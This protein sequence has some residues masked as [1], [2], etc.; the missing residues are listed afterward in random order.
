MKKFSFIFTTILLFSITTSA[1]IWRVNNM[2]GV[3]ADFTTAQAAHNAASAG[4][5]I[6]LE[7]SIYNYGSI[8]TTKQLV[9]ISIGSFLTQNP[10]NQFSTTP[11]TLSTINVNTGSNGSVFSVVTNSGININVPSITIL[12]THLT[13]G[14]GYVISINST[15]AVIMQCYLNSPDYVYI[16]S[17]NAIV[18]N[19]IL[20]YVHM[21]AGSTA[22][23]TNNVFTYTSSS[24][25][26]YNSVFQNNIIRGIQ[27]NFFNS[28]A[29]YN[30]HSGTG[31]P[32]GN[33]NEQNVNMATVF[34]NNTGTADKDF[35]LKVGSPA[36]TAGYGNI[37]MGAFGGST[38][39][40]LALQ[41]AIPAIT[42]L[43]T[44]AS[45]NG[46]NIQVTFSAKSNN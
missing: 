39:F 46:T 1:K 24:C 2:P 22:I 9:W 43:S 27:C 14:G 4:D 25:N 28:V 3:T 30:M 18:N 33:S 29:S 20:G 34:V 42:N 37:D 8:T 45:T 19:N 23:V 11:G 21:I 5:T 40:V 13:G 26:F 36:I 32:A 44:P 38:P 12:R 15:D 41:P 16:Q 17:T 31:I 10:G 6:H 7:P 35:Q